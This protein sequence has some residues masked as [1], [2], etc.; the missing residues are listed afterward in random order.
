MVRA[1]VHGLVVVSCLVLALLGQMPESSGGWASWPP[2]VIGP[3]AILASYPGPKRRA[4][5]VG[6][7]GDERWGWV[8]ASWPIPAT[9]SL[10]LWGLWVVSGRWGPGWVVGLPWLVWLWQSGGQVWPGLRRQPEWRG[11]GWLVWQ[12][13]RWALLGYLGLGL[14]QALRQGLAGDVGDVVRVNEAA[15]PLALG[16]GCGV[17]GREE[18]WVSVERQ[19]DGSYQA[20]L[21]G[22]FQLQVAG[23]DPFRARLLLLFLRQLAEVGPQ[24]R[25]GRTQ[26]GRAPFV[27]QA[28][29]GRMV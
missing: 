9:R 11:L 28:A 12:G 17:C 3:V 10:M 21:C 23:D 5:Q 6:W 22:H 7:P 15:T 25:G 18:G 24:R 14:N 8:W 27:R 4:K 26:D 29:G 1:R 20:E 13:Q 2:Q 19:A 16:L